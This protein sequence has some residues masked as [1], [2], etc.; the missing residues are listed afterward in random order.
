VLCLN[1]FDFSENQVNSS[2]LIIHPEF[3]QDLHCIMRLLT[4]DDSSGIILVERTGNNIPLYAILSHTWETDGEVTYND[5]E[6]GTGKNKAGYGKIRFCIEQAARDG[7]L[8]SWVDTCCIDKS[9]GP[10]VDEAIRSMFRWYS[11]AARC[12]V[13]L[14]DVPDSREPSAVE[15]A[16]AK[17]RW[18]TRGWTLQELIAPQSV[19]FFTSDRQSLGSRTSRM[20]Q[21]HDITGIAIEALQGTKPMSDFSIDERMAWAAKRGT[22]RAEDGA[23]CL[24]GLFEIH[25]P[26]MYGEGKQHADDRLRRTIQEASSPKSALLTD[27]KWVVPFERNQTFTGRETELSWLQKKLEAQDS[28]SKIAVTGL[29]GMGKTQL[30]LE[31]LYRTKSVHPS[32]SIMW[33]PATSAEA[34]HQGYLEIARKF[35]L[36][37]L[38]EQ[39]AD[40]KALVQEYLSRDEAGQ[41]LL[42]FDNADDIDMWL[43]DTANGDE[44]RGLIDFLPKSQLGC[45]IFTTRD[46]KAAVKLAKQNILELGQMNSETA[47]QVLEKCLANPQLH[48]TQE[49]ASIL[50]EELTYLPLAIIQAASYMNENGITVPE[51]L[52]LLR[53]KEEEVIDLL[54]ED[55]EDDGRYH[56]I[57][58][59]VATTWLI[60]FEQIRKHDSLAAE[61]LSFMACVDSREIPQSL[62]PPGLSRKKE[63]DALGTLSAY[64]FVSRRPAGVLDLHRLVHLATRNWLRKERL[65]GQWTER[66][67]ARLDEVFGD[68]DEE[69]SNVWRRYLSHATYAL[70]SELVSKDSEERMD[71]MWDYA[72]CLYNDGR[73]NEAETLFRQKME[74]EKEVYDMD[75]PKILNNKYWLASTAW[76][77]GRWDEAERLAVDATETIKT[78]L[79]SDHTDTL[80]FMTMLASIYRSQGRWDKA[81]QLELQVMKIYNLK[82]GAEHPSTLTSMDNLASTY[83][84]QGRYEEAEKLEL[85]VVETRKAILGTDHSDTLRSMANLGLIYWNQGQYDKAEILQRHVLESYQIKLGADHPSTLII[86]SNLSTTLRYQGRLEE[87]EPLLMHAIEV[88]RLKLEA[89]HPFMLVIMG[90]LAKALYYKGQIDEAEKLELEVWERS[91]IK[92]GSD[93]PDTL[94]SMSN[95]ACTWEEQGRKEE[96]LVLMEQCYN[97]CSRV[98]GP[99]HPMTLRRL[100]DYDSWMSEAKV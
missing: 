56:N 97:A 28:T 45:I 35:K 31:L 48:T 80:R 60:S 33:V 95:L 64:S 66:A 5:L 88:F 22:T 81:E 73:W 79:G 93:H 1:V 50:M 99:S 61:Y 7:L 32:Y 58:N 24:L 42:I 14:S 20:H 91:K 87:A 43:A 98:L 21:I 19:E 86:L 72:V 71:L 12:Y 49:D 23:Y 8:Y 41:W 96:A 39:N 47:C 65:L 16:F 53:E 36:L 13:Y 74:I 84:D 55:F 29:G 92:L 44:R 89:D 94:L 18:F 37:G 75:H 30:V 90:N 69:D 62:L 78:K 4:C 67:I 46:R 40:V 2:L 100:E 70:K 10:E 9:N 3:Y 11:G 59:P 26:V 15:A 27:V 52:M 77:Q 83:R 82:L 51:Y 34:L 68:C 6:E 25:M 85:Q 63:I 76:Q 57:K 38:E 17:S 54:S